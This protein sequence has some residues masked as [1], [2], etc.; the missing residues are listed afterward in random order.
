MVLKPVHAPPIVELRK[1]GSRRRV[2]RRL[3]IAVMVIAAIAIPML[4]LLYFGPMP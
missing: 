2:K 1:R 3:R 4:G